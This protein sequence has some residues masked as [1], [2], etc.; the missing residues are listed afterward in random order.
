[1]CGNPKIRLKMRTFRQVMHDIAIRHKVLLHRIQHLIT[2]EQ[3]TVM[4]PHP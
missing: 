3:D 2:F 1:M 4:I